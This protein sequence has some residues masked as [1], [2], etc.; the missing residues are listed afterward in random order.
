[1]AKVAKTV[2]V[3]GKTFPLSTLTLPAIGQ[4]RAWAKSRLPDP[5]EA[6]KPHLADFEPPV[7]RMM[8]EQALAEVRRPVTFGS[9]EFNGAMQC[10]EGLKEVLWLVLK[11]NGA[12]VSREASD[13]AADSMPADVAADV[14]GA[15]FGAF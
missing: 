12:D 1:M 9:P 5:I 13:A 8:L 15:A 3:D 10:G 11:Q 2:T 14:F 7:Q 4:L 6:I